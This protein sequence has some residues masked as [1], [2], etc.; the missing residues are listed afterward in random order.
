MIQ[1]GWCDLLGLEAASTAASETKRFDKAI[2]FLDY[3]F[4]RAG[5]VQ[6]SGTDAPM[7][8]TVARKEYER[9]RQL[10]LR[11]QAEHQQQKPQH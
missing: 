3:F 9:L 11:K 4:S 2:Q 5:Q 1:H 7:D 6:M 10:M 8:T